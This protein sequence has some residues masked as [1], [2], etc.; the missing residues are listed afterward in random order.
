MSA[1][2]QFQTLAELLAEVDAAGPRRYLIRGIW[3][4]GDYGVH[5]AEMKTGK[6]WNAADL[7]VSVASGT[8]WLDR[9]PVDAPGSV[10]VFVGEGGKAGTAR[11]IRAICDSR[12]LVAEELDI[13]VCARAP[14][15][16]DQRHLDEF[17]SQAR[18][19]RPALVILD[20]LYLSAGRAES[21]SLYKMG[22]VLEEAQLICAEVGASLFVVTHFNRGNSTGA[23]RITGAGPAEWGRVLLTADLKSRHK[24]PETK[25]TTVVVSVA[26]IG[27]EIPDQSF[28]VKRTVVSDDPDDL[29]A[30]L[31][32]S[33]EIVDTDDLD[34]A[35]DMP[36]ARRKLLEALEAIGDRGAT[37][38][39]LVDWIA[40]KYGHGLRR[41]TV[42]TEMNAAQGD[43]LVDSI[44]EAGKATIWFPAGVSGGVTGHPPGHL[45]TGDAGGVSSASACINADDTP[46][47]LA[48]TLDLSPEEIAK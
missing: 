18:R 44:A 36:P 16:H 43:G 3:P 19:Q 1:G 14:H 26:V 35:D 8:D 41:Q 5:A 33:V 37:G 28:R 38:R 45:P 42:S 6:T 21:G 13:V 12:G 29:D 9:F 32:Y 34:D 20:P 25:A 23:S 24:D 46:T 4:A 47:P 27:G 31:R 39:E 15:L 10:L 30:P 48:G 17:Y 11:R 22:A 40:D 7:A 2:L